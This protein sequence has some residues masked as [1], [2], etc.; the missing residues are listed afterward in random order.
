MFFTFLQVPVTVSSRHEPGR[1]LEDHDAQLALVYNTS[2]YDSL[3]SLQVMD[4]LVDVYMPDFKLWG[5]EE[6]R[7]YLLRKVVRTSVE[8]ADNSPL[9]QVPLT[10]FRL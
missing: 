8:N 3:E 10:Y 7:R 2:S 9:Q 6:S 4:G 1:E 5:A